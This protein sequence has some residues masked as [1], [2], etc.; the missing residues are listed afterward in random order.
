MDQ[1]LPDIR[2][3]KNTMSV[4]GA[5]LAIVVV[6][7][8][9]IAAY[10]VSNKLSTT[11]GISPTA[12]ASAPLASGKHSEEAAKTAQQKKAYQ[13]EKQSAIGSGQAYTK[14]FKQ[15]TGQEPLSGTANANYGKDWTSCS[16]QCNGCCLCTRD[17]AQNCSSD[18]TCG[19]CNSPLADPVH[20]GS[21]DCNQGTEVCCP[22]GCKSKNEGC[23]GGTISTP[24]CID[25]IWSP[26]PSSTCTTDTVRE[27]SNCG[28]VRT[29]QGTKDCTCVDTAW[30]PDAAAVCD[31]NAVTQTSNCGNVRTVGGTKVCSGGACMEVT[32][33][34]INADGTT[35]PAPLTTAQLSSLEVNKS[36]RLYLKA[37]IAGLQA[38]FGVTLNGNPVT[39]PGSVVW[40][41]FP[42]LRPAAG[43]SDTGKFISAYPFLVTSPGTYKFEGFVSS[44]P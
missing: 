34:Q 36:I 18:I 27:T 13:L 21:Q 24:G 1:K 5:I 2:R 3:K 31:T 12:P 8:V 40:S 29:E 23:G 22:S 10:F 9:A 14:T 26:D 41:D 11:A 25:S 15:F 44:N 35:A 37:N 7:G 4:V 16:S 30:S 39:L 43:Y 33:Y 32:A 20:C 19:S 42:N 17:S 38:R 6:V 28:N